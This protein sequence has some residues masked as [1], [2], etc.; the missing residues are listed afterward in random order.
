MRKLFAFILV[1][2]LLASCLRRDDFSD[3]PE[4]EYKS[5]FRDDRSL[6]IVISFTDGDGDLGLKDNQT[7]YP[8]GPCDPYYKNLVVDPYRLVDGEF[9]LS[10]L[11]V[12]GDCGTDTNIVYDTVGYDQRIKFIEPTGKDK[13][14]EGDMEIL[15]NGV[16]DEFPG[17]AIKFKVRLM[18]RALNFSNEVETDVVSIKP[19]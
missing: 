6:V 16:L 10:R 15:L 13:T 19:L 11:I 17:D 3:I 5:I 12:P 1:T 7:Q 18:D 14:L 4:I 8:F 9:V 2:T